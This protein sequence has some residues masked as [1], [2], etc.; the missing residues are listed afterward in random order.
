[1]K[2]NR[3]FERLNKDTMTHKLIAILIPVLFFCGCGTS[4]IASQ[5]PSNPVGEPR[6]PERDPRPET[7]YTHEMKPEP[8]REP[9]EIPRG[10]FTARP[11]LSFSGIQCDHIRIKGVNPL[12]EGGL[13]ISLDDLAGE[14]CYPYSGKFI[15]DYGKRG[16]S[17]HTGIDIKAIPNDTIRAAFAGVVRMSK[18]YS[19]YGNTVVIRHYCGFETVYAHASKNLVKANDIVEAG[20]PV[21]LAGR[22]GRATTEHLHFEMRAAGE[23]VDPKILVDPEQRKLRA[24][25][26]YVSDRGGAVVAANSQQ[27]LILAREQSLAQRATTDAARAS[28]LAAST[29]GGK[30]KTPAQPAAEYYKVKKGDTL[31]AIAAR[32]KTTAKN[33]SALNG[34]KP[35]ALLQINQ[36]LRVR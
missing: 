19:G 4:R 25:W 9:A 18:N 21:A 17:R 30:P 14:F 2:K 15:S 22:T 7:Q 10:A 26:L 3:N 6:I 27:E 35:T 28:A 13:V 5:S 16:N 29:D 12:P 31:S 20:T 33:L 11:E 34:I 8:K 1:M 24:G 23:P 32:H 36:K